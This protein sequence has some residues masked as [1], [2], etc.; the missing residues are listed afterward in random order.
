MI[1]TLG[2]GL[3][4]TTAIVSAIH[5]VLLAPLPYSKS[6]QL[7]TVQEL[8]NEGDFGTV[9]FATYDEWRSSL[10]S[11][12][13]LSAIATRSFTI[14]GDAEPEQLALLA[15]THEAFETLG[16]RPL[17]GREFTPQD[18]VR[19]APRVVVLS[20]EL[21][22]RRFGRDA[23]IVGRTIR[24]SDL[25]FEV[26]GVMP[27]RVRMIDTEWR[28]EPIA[29]WVPLRYNTTLEW[30][31][32]TCRHLRIIGRLGD[33]V[34][35]DQAAREV[36]Q[37][38]AVMRREHPSAY[39]AR[40]FTAVRSLH[41][42]IVGRQVASSLWIVLALAAVMLL[43]A[44]AN[45]SSLRLSELF[46]RRNE[47]LVRQSLGATP[48]RVAWML[49]LESTMQA[50]VASLVGIGIAYGAI[51]W[52]RVRTSAFLPRAADLAVDP[53]VVMICVAMAI[54]SGI[55][56]GLVPAMRARRW[57]LVVNERGIV[58]SRSSAQ[59]LLVGV[60]VAL[61]VVL[62]IG[63]A[64]VLRSVRNLFAT[65]A[66]FEAA[67]VVSFRVAVNGQRY[68]DANALTALYTRFLGEGRQLAG[69]QS[70]ALTSQLPFAEDD[71]NATFFV[72]ERAGVD[73]QR[74]A[75][76]ADYFSTLRIPLKRGRAFA[77]TDIAKSEP[78]VILNEAATHA[79]WSSGDAL[80]RRV[81]IG[82]G[83]DN[84]YRRVVGIVG[85]VAPGDL[86]AK[87]RPQ[88]YL[89]LEQFGPPSEVT[90]V[91]RMN[92]PDATP[93]R[94][95]LRQLDPDIAFY[96]VA[97]L[98]SL[99]AGSEARRR[100]ILGMLSAFSI[101]TLVLAM[102]GV[103]GV[104][105]LF[106]SSRTRE[107]GL[108]MA[109]GASSPSV[110]RLVLSQGLQLVGAAMLVGVAASLLLGR[111]LAAILF[112][113]TNGDPATLLPVLALLLAAASIACAV[114]AWRASRVSPDAALRDE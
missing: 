38:T 100:F 74:F 45:A 89:P 113:V 114:P 23:S 49:V 95:L 33:G 103:Y 104:L 63:T 73:A 78:V 68:E 10:R 109:L 80:G 83:D 77:Q 106:V 87:A 96:R 62:L 35:L 97:T 48:M 98:T 11:F 110:F 29:A 86:G 50:I 66:G 72:D 31:C 59:K 17:L 112:G 19:G 20:H 57:S 75:V 44:I 70:M 58:S 26:I 94:A 69:V 99:V 41:D 24:M 7:V 61:S 34:T 65:P 15:V 37:R 107:L 39:P 3:G 9:G 85:D 21:W 55:A 81:R 6:E 51:G 30:A 47:L 79:L 2:L 76:S 42:V 40:I 92:A 16:V 54:V 1:A 5:G 102:I 43:A 13:S 8:E 84:P 56:I 101:V 4:A 90:G 28:G 71:D 36:E 60:N 14:T 32:R 82:G 64:L 22:S 108:R 53:I 18:D 91:A 111:F 105:S 46:V 25:E 88:A 12:A 52:L 93:L 27:P 67:N